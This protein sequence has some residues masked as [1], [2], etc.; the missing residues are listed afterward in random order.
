[1]LR[2]DTCIDFSAGAL[3]RVCIALRCVTPAA[4]PSS[5]AKAI[6]ACISRAHMSIIDICVKGW[7]SWHSGG[8]PLHRDVVVSQHVT[9]SLSLSIMSAE[10][11]HAYSL[12]S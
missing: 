11:A 8:A 4:V 10:R 6:V 3:M 5:I 9:R 7:N 12:C 1:M 2:D